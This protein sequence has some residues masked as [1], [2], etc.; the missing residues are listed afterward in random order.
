MGVDEL[1]CVT[2]L[3]SFMNKFFS[4]DV[5]PGGWNI[6]AARI[7]R[8]QGLFQCHFQ[9]FDVVN[10]SHK[11]VFEYRIR[12]GAV[13]KVI[14]AS[15]QPDTISSIQLNGTEWIIRTHLSSTELRVNKSTI[16][17]LT[18][19]NVCFKAMDDDPDVINVTLCIDKESKLL[20]SQLISSHNPRDSVADT[21]RRCHGMAVSNIS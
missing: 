1:F 9:S 13:A 21:N 10:Q 2:A 3:D 17:Q 4:Q 20:F 6:S 19:Q 5:L 16:E 12:S 15:L 11:Q 18:I 8:H 14:N 7:D